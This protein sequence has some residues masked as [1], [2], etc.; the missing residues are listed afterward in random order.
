[1]QPRIAVKRIWSDEDILLLAFEVCDGRSLFVTEAYSGRDWG[2]TSSDSLKSFGVQIH[3]GIFDLQAGNDG[4]EYA[5][6][7]FRA[8]FHW[9][10][11][12]ALFISTTQQ[13]GFVEF[14]EN[15]VAAEARMFLRTEADL[16]DQF[17]AA[18]PSLDRGDGEEAVL[19][20]FSV[21]D[22]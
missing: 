9:F 11:P 7:V 22:A 20:C 15:R 13:S 16:L 3:G 19:Q 6:G 5:G 21:G 1:M 8:R 18:L 14:K 4:P 10:R 2:T 17:R 12:R